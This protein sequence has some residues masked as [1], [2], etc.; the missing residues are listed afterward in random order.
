[1][2]S[3]IIVLKYMETTMRLKTFQYKNQ[4]NI[5]DFQLHVKPQKDNRDI[6]RILRSYLTKDNHK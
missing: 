4:L 5:Q 1:M 3:K 6:Q 2:N